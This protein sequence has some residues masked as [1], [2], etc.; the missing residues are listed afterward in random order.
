MTPGSIESMIEM[1]NTI[2]IT[3]VRQT[4]AGVSSYTS[5]VGRGCPGLLKIAC[6][7]ED[8]LI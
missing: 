6:G 4:F 8:F 1:A 2:G 3:K 7:H 5:R